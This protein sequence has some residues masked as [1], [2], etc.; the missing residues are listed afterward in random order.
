MTCKR[1]CG[2]L[3]LLLTAP[4][5]RVISALLHG[6]Q[7]LFVLLLFHNPR[8]EGSHETATESRNQ[9][10]SDF[11]NVNTAVNSVIFI[12]FAAGIQ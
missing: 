2:N 6:N 4:D 9:V 10:G 3:M 11:F 1:I 7:V 8:I 12:N 5:N